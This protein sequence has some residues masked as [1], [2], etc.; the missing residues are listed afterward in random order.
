MCYN[1]ANRNKLCVDNYLIDSVEN[2]QILAL[3]VSVI[4]HR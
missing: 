2:E 4:F 1:F 3:L